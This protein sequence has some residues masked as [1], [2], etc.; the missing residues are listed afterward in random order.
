MDHDTIS[1][2]IAAAGVVGPMTLG[3][4][5]LWVT[6]RHPTGRAE[7]RIRADLDEVQARASRAQLTRDRADVDFTAAKR[8]EAHLLDALAQI[9]AAR[10]RTA[11]AA[12]DVDDTWTRE[13]VRGATE[14]HPHH[15]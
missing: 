10:Q 11:P 9:Q 2:W 3:G 6:R 15:R 12:R 8:D 1:L 7:R 5:T 4:L 14:V 13:I